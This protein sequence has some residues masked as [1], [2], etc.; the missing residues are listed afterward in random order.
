VSVPRPPLPRSV[1]GAGCVSAFK[2][3]RGSPWGSGM[4]SITSQSAPAIAPLRPVGRQRR[5]LRALWYA[6]S[7]RSQLLLAFVLIDLVAVVVA[8]SV[9]IVRARTQVRAEMASSMRLAR[10][11]VS[12]AAKFV[13]RQL[14]ADQ[15]LAELPEQLQSLRHVQIKVI[16]A[17]GAAFTAPLRSRSAQEHLP[18]PAWFSWLVGTPIKRDTVPVIVNGQTV[19]Q[20]EIIGE[21]A[22]ETAEVWG[23]LVAL[24]GVVLGLNIAMIGI[25]YF[26]FGRVLGPLA[27]LA[28]GLSDLEHQS[29]GVRL[30][31]SNAREL[32]GITDQ[33]NALAIALETARSENQQLNR[34]LITAQDD[35][36]RRT[37][38]ELHDEVGPCLFGLKAYGSSIANTSSALPGEIGKGL[39][40]CAHEILAVT[41]HLQAINR[42]MLDRLRPMALGHVP[43]T[44]IL[45]QLVDERSRQ[46]PQILF[47][48]AAGKLARSYA[49][50]VD[51]TIYRCIQES[52]T[53][54]IRHAQA[55]H[56]SVEVG[57]DNETGLLE[58]TVQDDGRGMSVDTPTGFGIRGMRERVEALGGRHH[59]A[60]EP[61]RGTCSKVFI[62]VAESPRAVADVSKSHGVRA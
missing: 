29:Y 56:V 54:A 44:D 50:S 14:S 25:L 4:A 27:A 35:E 22:D 48:Y 26:L 53:N 28:T 11:L 46:H 49:D 55:K 16:D 41:E 5:F 32:A 8:G 10:F 45:R 52:L 36:R 24:G 38:L 18:A 6:R 3:W 13:D 17:A 31:R 61:G 1:T 15:F 60:S 34:R 23:D 58:L 47:N 42:S 7:I 9:A 43:L 37:A 39:S 59:I 30:A 21:P 33:F 2:G 40:E 12:D 57:Y 62:P 19:G 51:L 20:V